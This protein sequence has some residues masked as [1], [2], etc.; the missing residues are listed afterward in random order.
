[1]STGLF[2]T[3]TPQGH[4]ARRHQ[5]LRR[6]ADNLSTLDEFAERLSQHGDVALAAREIGK[7]PTYGRTLLQRLVKRLGEQ[8]C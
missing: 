1:M 5:R 2:P 7:T 3:S 8:A 6:A 4:G